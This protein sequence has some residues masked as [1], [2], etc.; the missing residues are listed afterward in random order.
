MKINDNLRKGK[1]KAFSINEILIV[2]VVV[3]ILSTIAI[4]SLGDFSAKAYRTEAEANLRG[5]KTRLDEYR[6]RNFEFTTEFSKL[7]FIAP[8]KAP[9]GTSVYTY[10]M[11]EADKTTFIAQATADKDYD[12]DDVYEVLTINQNG[13]IEVKV[14]D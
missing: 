11:I 5:I 10:E 6:L 14:Q 9:E 8:L 13:K 2:L 7:N 4:A 3:G 1:L 12:G